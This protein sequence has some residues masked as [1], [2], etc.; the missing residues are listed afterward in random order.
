MKKSTSTT[1]KDFIEQIGKA[2]MIKSANK[3]KIKST[4]K[5]T[6]INN[7]HTQSTWIL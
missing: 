6:N 3:L 7:H 5:P 1:Y 2:K 4:I